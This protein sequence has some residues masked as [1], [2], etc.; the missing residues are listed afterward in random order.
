MCIPARCAGVST[1]S[2][3]P[4]RWL[5]HLAERCVAAI[6]AQRITGPAWHSTKSAAFFMRPLALRSRI[7]T[8]PTGV[9]QDLF[10]DTLLALDA[11][12]GKRIWS[13]Q[14]VHHDIWDRD[15]PSPPSLLT[16]TSNGKRI[17]AVAQTTKQGYLYLF[18]RVNGQPL[19]PIMEQPVPASNVPGERSWPTQPRPCG[20][21]PFARQYLSGEMLTNRTPGSTRVRRRQ[22]QHLSAAP[23]NSFPSAST[24]RPSSSPVSMAARNGAAPPSISEAA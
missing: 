20:P 16:V 5:R 12:T 23:A 3:I 10:A 8:A 19:F 14:G 18:D 22:I 7:S 21:A 15:F 1:P 17:D 24:S 4:A 2:R 9:G 13:F 11:S 6:P